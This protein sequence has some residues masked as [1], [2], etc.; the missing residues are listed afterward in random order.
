MA[1]NEEIDQED[2]NAPLD[3][4]SIDMKIDKEQSA[5]TAATKSKFQLKSSGMGNKLEWPQRYL[6][7]TEKNS[8]FDWSDDKNCK[9]IPLAIDVTSFMDHDS[10]REMNNDQ[11]KHIALAGKVNLEDT[12][13]VNSPRPKLYLVSSGTKTLI[14]PASGVKGSFLIVHSCPTILPKRI[15]KCEFDDYN[16]SSKKTKN[17]KLIP[18]TTQIYEYVNFKQVAYITFEHQIEDCLF[19]NGFYFFLASNK[20]IYCREFDSDTTQPKYFSSYN[21]GA[22]FEEYWLDNADKKTVMSS[23]SI[24]TFSSFSQSSK[25][26]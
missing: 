26:S 12:L 21:T 18:Q 6:F 16:N 19:A 10:N 20:T 3:Q 13:L 1:Q 25:R 24:T 2:E 8:K 4:V 5:T 11:L 22:N 17:S 15:R 14:I 9:F 23:L 7:I